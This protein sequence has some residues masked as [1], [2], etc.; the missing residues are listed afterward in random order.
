M[1]LRRNADHEFAAVVLC[2]DGFGY[3]L[4]TILHI[5]HDFRDFAL[6]QKLELAKVPDLGQHLERDLLAL[7]ELV[8]YLK[9]RG[10]KCKAEM[11]AAG[12]TGATASAVRMTRYTTHG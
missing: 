1:N 11:S 7:D 5:L 4:A 8:E 9:A 6:Q 2:R 3:R 12:I 10:A